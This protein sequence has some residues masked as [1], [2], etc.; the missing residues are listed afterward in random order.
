MAE[1]QLTNADLAGLWAAAAGNRVTIKDLE[2][3][4]QKIETKQRTKLLLSA[5]VWPTR[6]GEVGHDRFQQLVRPVILSRCCRIDSRAIPNRAGPLRSARACAG[7][8]ET[9]GAAAKLIGNRVV[10]SNSIDVGHRR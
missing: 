6:C 9:P 5:Q 4:L 3:F 2:N 1:L 7:P 10:Q 8:A